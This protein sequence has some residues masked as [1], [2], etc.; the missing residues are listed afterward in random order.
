M[1]LGENIADNG[2]LNNAF[3]AYKNFKRRHGEELM[4]PGFETY[5]Q[6]QLFFIAFGSVSQFISPSL[7]YVY[8]GKN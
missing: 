7:L 3:I 6:D 1:T 4:L 8:D 2:G 5:T